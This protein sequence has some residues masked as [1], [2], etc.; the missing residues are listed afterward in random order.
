[1]FGLGLLAIDIIAWR[2]VSQLF[3]SERLITGHRTSR[4]D[5][6]LDAPA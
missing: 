3:D 2:I 6:V 5:D 1:V 4:R